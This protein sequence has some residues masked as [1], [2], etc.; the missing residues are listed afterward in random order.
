MLVVACVLFINMGLAD[1]IQETIG[2][3]LKFLSCVKCLSFWAALI[4]LL[5]GRCGIVT[6]VGASFLLSYI[7]LWADL[8]LSALNRK[9]NEFYEQISAPKAHPHKK[10]H[11]KGGSDVP[12]V[13]HKN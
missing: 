1:A 8:G 10:H 4:Y 3:R 5:V 12:E 2:I 6:A 9:Y 7:A 11:K 13:R